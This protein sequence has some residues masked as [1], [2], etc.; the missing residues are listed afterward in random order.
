MGSVGSTDAESEVSSVFS[1]MSVKGE[2]EIDSGRQ[3]TGV[4][5]SE[6]RA[7]DVKIAPFSLS[8]FATANSIRS[9]LGSIIASHRL[10]SS[11]FLGY[12][13]FVTSLSVP[14]CSG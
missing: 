9:V 12:R 4:L 8:L 14:R 13:L 5:L 3:A 7:R 11:P 6:P 1:K 10:P 2:K